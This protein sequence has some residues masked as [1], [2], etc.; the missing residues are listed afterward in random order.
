MNR[1]FIYVLRDPRTNQIRYVGK[2][3]SPERRKYDHIYIARTAREINH[4]TKWIRL[5]L[6]HGLTPVLEV[7]DEVEEIDWPS[8][9]VAY[10]SYFQA[11]GCRLVNGTLGGEG[12]NNPTLET[13]AKIGAKSRAANKGRKFSEEHR[14]KI[15]A[16][17]TGR[18]F[19]LEHRANI[20]ARMRII[21]ANR[22]LSSDHR[23]KI[24]AALT[25][26]KFS[27]EHCAK[28]SDARWRRKC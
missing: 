25:G 4:R 27:A 6:S 16:A 8:W 23:E 13:R 7:V 28:I 22:P 11:E 12:L 26:R 10:I 17:L 3:K 24:S 5:L 1:V 20:G 2:S 19:S 15:S 9:E 14:A 21:N 18:V